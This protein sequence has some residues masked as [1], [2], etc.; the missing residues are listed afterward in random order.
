MVEGKSFCLADEVR[1]AVRLASDGHPEPI[2]IEDPETA[3]AVAWTGQ[4]GIVGP[5]FL[6]T[7]RDSRTMFGYPTRKLAQMAATGAGRGHSAFQ[8][9]GRARAKISKFQIFL[10]RLG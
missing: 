4:Y 3:F 10:A 5:P 7:D 6:Y 2:H 9:L 1:S 8:L